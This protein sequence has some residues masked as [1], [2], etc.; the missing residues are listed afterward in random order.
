[1]LDKSRS[2]QNKFG[3]EFGSIKTQASKPFISNTGYNKYF[4]KESN[5]VLKSPKNNTMPKL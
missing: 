2:S 5:H 1:M 4:V 3:L